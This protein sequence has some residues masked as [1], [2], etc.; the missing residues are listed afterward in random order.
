MSPDGG[1]LPH[2]SPGRVRHEGV[3]WHAGVC[4]PESARD[5]I[6]IGTRLGFVSAMFNA[7]K[8]FAVIVSCWPVAGYQF[9]C[10]WLWPARPSALGRHSFAWASIRTSAFGEPEMSLPVC[11]IVLA[12]LS[13]CIPASETMNQ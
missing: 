8:L 3:V 5:E 6:E 10:V 2:A 4:A 1:R 11:F 7:K 12:T 9:V 13:Q